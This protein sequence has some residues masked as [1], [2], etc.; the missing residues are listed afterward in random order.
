M[1]EKKRQL[2]TAMKNA[3]TFMEDQNINSLLQ[4]HKS[5]S[6]HIKSNVDQA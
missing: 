5:S 2:H 3:I 6:G 1:K 4:G